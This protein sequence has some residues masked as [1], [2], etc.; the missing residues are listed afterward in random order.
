MPKDTD[1]AFYESNFERMTGDRYWTQP[2]LTSALLEMVDVPGVIWEPAAGRG[3]ISKVLEDFGRVVVCS[4]VDMSECEPH[5]EDFV[6]DF[7][8]Q[9]TPPSFGTLTPVEGIVTN[10]PYNVPRGIA[11]DFARHA[12]SLLRQDNGLNFVAMLMRSEFCNARTRRDLFGECR[13][14]TTQVVLTSRPRWD[15][16]FRDKPIASPRHNFS[17]FVWERDGGGPASQRPPTQL[18]HYR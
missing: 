8:S 16:W 18:F 7:L 2:W 12:L 11:V 14:Y 1:P 5:K 17:W 15:W 3:D 10:P 4:D 9:N 6:A 13:E